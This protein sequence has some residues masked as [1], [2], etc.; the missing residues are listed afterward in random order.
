MND[1]I[2]NLVTEHGAIELD[3]VGIDG[4]AFAV[5]GAVSRQARRQGWPAEARDALLKEMTRGDYDHLLGVAL[6]VTS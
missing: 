1:I 6:E 5:M 3:L 2:K 4:N